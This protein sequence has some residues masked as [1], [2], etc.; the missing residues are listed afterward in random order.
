MNRSTTY[1]SIV[2]IN[3]S[4]SLFILINSIL[5]RI[6]L[7]KRESSLPIELWLE[8]LNVNYFSLAVGCGLFCYALIMLHFYS[9]EREK[10]KLQLQYS[11][12]KLKN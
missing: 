11:L 4:I 6:E 7:L 9:K 2:A 10:E 3:F 1:F 12:E 8:S 5:S